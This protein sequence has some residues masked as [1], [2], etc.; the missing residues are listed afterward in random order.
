MRILVA[1]LLLVAACHHSKPAEAPSNTSTDTPAATTPTATTGTCD[2]GL[3]M[4]DPTANECR[5]WPGGG[6]GH[7]GCSERTTEA[8][9][10]GKC[11]TG[12]SWDGH[13]DC[14]CDSGAWDDTA[15]ACK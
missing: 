6:Y 7:A 11:F 3:T 14:A 15:H 12:S 9:G 2:D 1:A 4:W 5:L 10:P 8:P 13:C